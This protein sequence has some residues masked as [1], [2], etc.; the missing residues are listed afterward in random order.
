MSVMTKYVTRLTLF[1][2]GTR[3]LQIDHINKRTEHDELLEI[4]KR[5]LADVGLIIRCRLVKPRHR[6]EREHD[7]SNVVVL[8]FASEELERPLSWWSS[9]FSRHQERGISQSSVRQW[10]R[11][12]FQRVQGHLPE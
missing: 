1:H 10:R 11:S 12:G 2:G 7:S 3:V 9:H 4:F 6:T 8:E 5:R